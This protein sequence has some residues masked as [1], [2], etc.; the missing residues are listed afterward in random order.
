MTWW[1]GAPTPFSIFPATDRC[2]IILAA[3]RQVLPDSLLLFTFRTLR[4]AES[5]TFPTRPICPQRGC[6]Q[7]QPGRFRGSGAVHGDRSRRRGG[8]SRSGGLPSRFPLF[9][10]P[11][12]TQVQTILSSHD[13]AKTPP[14]GELLERLSAMEALGCSIA[15]LAVMP[16]KK[17]GMC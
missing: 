4:E 14:M 7:K 13:F 17:K 3:L 12:Q 1:N 6:D 5:M 8:A 2:S 10:W 16:H 15:K 9:R 11:R